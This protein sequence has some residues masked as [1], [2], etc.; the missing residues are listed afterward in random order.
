M[1]F[2]LGTKLGM[3]QVF[4]DDG[5][6]VPVTR[7]AAGPCVVTQVKNAGKNGVNAVQIGF[8]TQKLFRVP[9]AQQGHLKGLATV[10]FMRDF[11]TLGEEHG[12]KHGDTFTVRVFAPGE[13]VQVVGTSKGKGFQG[14]VKRHGFHGHPASHGH[15]DQQ[16]MP[17]SIGATTPQRVFKGKRMAGHMGDARV[18]VKNLEVVGVKPEENELLIKGAVPGARGGLLLI[19]TQE[20]TITVEQTA[21]E[22]GQTEKVIS[23]QVIGDQTGAGHEAALGKEEKKESAVEEKEKS[24]E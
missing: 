9:K 8:G 24:N 21:E 7:V 3:T 10:R 20:G 19:S 18:T 11:R 4:R 16:R 23:D 6:V 13:K 12:L 1:K 2:I 22:K 15:K 5:T 14:V 17:G